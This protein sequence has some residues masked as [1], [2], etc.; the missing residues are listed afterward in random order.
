MNAAPA[1]QS[2][3]SAQ[4]EPKAE[5]PR[6]KQRF[7]VGQSRELRFSLHDDVSPEALT[8]L[9]DKRAWKHFAVT[10]WQLFLTIASTVV[11]IKFDNPWIWIPVAF[12]QGF[13]VFNY[14]VMLHEVVHNAVFVHQRPG[15]MRFLALLYSIPSGISA[16]QFTRWHLDHHNELGSPTDDP[17]RYHLSPKRVARWYKLL[18]FT[19]ALFPIY[20]RAAKRE[21]STYPAELQNK[22][23]WERRAA[24]AF[25]LSIA[26]GL[27]IFDWRMAMRVHIVPV[28]FIFPIAF[29]MNRLGQHYFINPLDPAQWSTLVKANFLWRIA[30]LNSSY[31]L[32]HHY[33]P[34]V[35]LYNLYQTHR[36]L[37]TFYR[38]RGMSA[39]NYSQ[40]LW[41]WLVKNGV[42]HTNWRAA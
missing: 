34:G 22:I 17:K 14:T 42:P 3:V 13:T 4:P 2:P 33:Y 40:L 6:G 21:T 19:P 1:I 10:A 39:V 29:A 32:E 9:H 41:G 30:F 24:M 36:L 26:I 16:S 25:H 37:G 23:A 27:L 5:A 35:P 20:F 28:F 15:W 12:V 11:L 18:Y 31:H 7:Y 8:T 38:K